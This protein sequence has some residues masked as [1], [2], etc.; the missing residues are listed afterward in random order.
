MEVRR[1]HNSGAGT[2]KQ[3]GGQSRDEWDREQNEGQSRGEGP[4]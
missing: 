3:N 2:E 1:L 4:C